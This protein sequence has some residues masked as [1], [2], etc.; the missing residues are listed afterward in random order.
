MTASQMMG[1]DLTETGTVASANVG[2]RHVEPDGRVFQYVKASALIAQYAYVKIS[3]DGLFTAAEATTTTNPS[4]EPALVGCAQVAI[5][6]GSHG[7]V[8]RRGLHTG[9][10]AASCAQD[11]K[12]Y[13]TATAGVFDDTATT[14]VNGLK[15][16]TTI[17]GAS[18]VLAMAMDEMSTS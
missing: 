16:L 13:T 2:Q 4:T 11:V 3:G 1:V 6:S 14:L 12:I 15:L 10:F 18:S 5:A 8:Q 7:W 17:V 9:K